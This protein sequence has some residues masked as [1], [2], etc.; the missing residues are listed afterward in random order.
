MIAMTGTAHA[1][2]RHFCWGANLAVNGN[3]AT[4]K[5]YMTAAYASSSEGRI[6]LQLVANENRIGCQERPNEGIYINESG[7]AYGYANIMNGSAYPLK[8]YGV[9]WT[10]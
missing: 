1:E 10:C 7:C 2:E 6:C 3:C 8:V 5:W 9:F 4:A